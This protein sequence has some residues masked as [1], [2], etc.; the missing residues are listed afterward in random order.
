[1]KSYIVDGRHSAS[2]WVEGFFLPKKLY[3]TLKEL[4]EKGEAQG[5]SV[6]AL[7]DMTDPY[8][9][10]ILSVKEVDYKKRP[11]KEVRDLWLGEPKKFIVNYE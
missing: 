5:L 8:L 4:L 11:L 3:P 2:G 9:V 6:I 10:E 1:M 7:V